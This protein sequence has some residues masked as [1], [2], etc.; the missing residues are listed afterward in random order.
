MKRRKT[1]E[2]SQC[3]ERVVVVGIAI[4]VGDVV[5]SRASRARYALRL[6]EPCRE[7]K[8][9]AARL[10]NRATEKMPA[11]E[12]TARQV[13]QQKQSCQ[14]VALLMLTIMVALKVWH[15]WRRLGRWEVNRLSTP[16]E[17]I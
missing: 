11:A 2:P 1:Q 4:V 6:A 16:A 5:K 9:V 8:A 17:F 13:K 15:K 3:S 10:A 12:C 14:F 7:N